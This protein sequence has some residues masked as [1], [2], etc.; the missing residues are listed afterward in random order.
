[1]SDEVKRGVGIMFWIV[2][3]VFL[4]WNLFGCAIYLMDRLS[5]DEALSAMKNGEA[6]LASR[7]AYPIW[8]TAAFAIAVWGGLVGAALIIMRKKS[9]APVFIISLIA[10]VICFIPNFIMPVVQAAGGETYW[11]MPVIVVVI[12]SIEIWWSR[13]KSAL[14][15][16]N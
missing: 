11:V 4:I 9:A 3:V 14:G 1:M 16:L 12:G 10:A 5:S 13:R 6:L 8:A 7:E 2:A 15:Y